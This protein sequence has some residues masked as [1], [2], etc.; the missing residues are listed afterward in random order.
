MHT[1]ALGL[2]VLELSSN[3][4]AGAGRS[5]SAL[6]RGLPNLQVLSLESCCLSLEDVQQLARSLPRSSLKR[7]DLADNHLRSKGLLA[8]A[9]GIRM[10]RMEDLGLER[11][12]IG[13]GEALA[14]LRAALEKRP[15][16]SLRLRG[17]R[18]TDAQEAAFFSS[19]RAAPKRFGSYCPP[20]C[21]CFEGR[22]EVM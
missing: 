9:G 15:V 19:L 5:L 17:N 18:L 21:N 7:L 16:V 11:N 10:S 6:V 3:T 12:E 2:A 13:I 14:E 4:L 20:G 22:G 1:A 8:I